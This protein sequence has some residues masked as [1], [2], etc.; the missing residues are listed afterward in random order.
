LREAY[1]IHFFTEVQKSLARDA[2]LNLRHQ[3]LADW[4][5]RLNF[6]GAMPWNFLKTLEK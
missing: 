6:D 3:T 4:R 1:A 2:S 5:R